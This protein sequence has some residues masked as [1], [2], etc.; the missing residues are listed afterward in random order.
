MDII[1]SRYWVHL[2]EPDDSSNESSIFQVKF[3]ARGY[4]VGSLDFH[5]LTGKLY[6]Y[7]DV[8]SVSHY[9]LLISLQITK[10]SFRWVQ[11]KVI[12]DRLRL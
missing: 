8:A 12:L 5:K 3:Q 10:S 2:V 6:D 7:K 1:F 11:L 4:D 9:T